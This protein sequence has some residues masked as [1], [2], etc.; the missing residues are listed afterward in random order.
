MEIAKHLKLKYKEVEKNFELLQTPTS[1]NM[2]IGEDDDVELG[3]IIPSSSSSN[4]EDDFINSNLVK[5]VDNLLIKAGLTEMEQTILKYRYGL[6]YSEEKIL[7]DI[8]KIYGVTRERI[9]QKEAKAIIKLRKYS[10]TKKFAA[11]LDNPDKAKEQLE[12]MCSW[13]YFH[14]KS[15]VVYNLSFDDEKELENMPKNKHH[16]KTIYE[17]IPNYSKEEIDAEISKLKGNNKKIFYLRNGDNLEWPTPS[18]KFNNDMKKRYYGIVNLIKRHL[19]VSSKYIQGTIYWQLNKMAPNYSKDDYQKAISKLTKWEKN[20]IF[21]Y[22]GDNLD[23]PIDYK[24]EKYNNQI[25]KILNH[26]IIILSKIKE[27]KKEIKVT[28]ELQEF[29]IRA[30]EMLKNPLLLTLL[31]DMQVKD[32]IILALII[33][34]YIENRDISIEDIANLFEVDICVIK[35]DYRRMLL[36]FKDNI[37]DYIDIGLITINNENSKVLG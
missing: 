35:D 26:I 32:A 6:N 20:I 31:L 29:Y 4:L 30:L 5:E 19:A 13:H 8:G 37:N 23:V 9:R 33:L 18:P 15:S 22:Y 3:D 27:T 17:M 28:N 24:R 10:E 11:Y 12:K 1:L 34:S 7:E 14:P 36:K 2:K 25:N 16:F 21:S